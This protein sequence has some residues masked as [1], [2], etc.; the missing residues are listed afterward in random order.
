[1]LT[2]DMSAMPKIE[3]HISPS[4]RGEPRRTTDLANIG[5]TAKAQNAVNTPKIAFTTLPAVFTVFT[6]RWIK[7]L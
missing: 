4:A 6:D 5:I 3:P 7:Q 2:V 1:M